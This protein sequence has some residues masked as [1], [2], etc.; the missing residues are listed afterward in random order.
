MLREGAGKKNN[1]YRYSAAKPDPASNSAVESK[2]DNNSGFLVPSIY[3]E[4]GN[5]KRET[6]VTAR[7]TADYSSSHENATDDPPSE[8]REPESGLIKPWRIVE[9]DA[10]E[11]G[12][13]Q[14]LTDDKEVVDLVD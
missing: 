1:P 13:V 9:F 12:P 6:D 8:T 14:T 3:R 7:N 4:Q 5:Q 11:Q 2:P 10:V